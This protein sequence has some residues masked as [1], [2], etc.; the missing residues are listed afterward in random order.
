MWLSEYYDFVRGERDRV[1]DPIRVK[2]HYMA[3]L[4]PG[5]LLF[6]Y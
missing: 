6:K 3:L 1:A 5:L 4:P 2:T